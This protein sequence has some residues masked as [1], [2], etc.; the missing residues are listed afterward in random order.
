MSLEEILKKDALGEASAA[1]LLQAREAIRLEFLKLA[2]R[3]PALPEAP[4]ANVK[5][6]AADV[7]ERLLAELK[8]LLAQS[9][10]AALALLEENAGSLRPLLGAAFDEIIDYAQRFNFKAARGALQTLKF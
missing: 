6:M 4:P 3:L 1:S 9:D 2:A 5:P 10:T 8:E 7:L